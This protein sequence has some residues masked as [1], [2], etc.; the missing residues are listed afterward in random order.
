MRVPALSVNATEAR[1]QRWRAGG[2][3]TAP[4]VLQPE[5]TAA[6]A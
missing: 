6:P 3:D 5:S 4:V 1:E 2:G